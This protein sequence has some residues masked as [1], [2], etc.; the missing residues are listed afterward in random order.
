MRRADRLWDSY[1]GE[2]QLKEHPK[3]DPAK[4][5]L[6][7]AR[8]R[9]AT[10]VTIGQIAQRLYLGSWKSLNHKLYLRNRGKRAAKK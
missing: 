3:I 9:R 7:A 6:M 5:A 10:T 4:L 2:R 8:L 1:L